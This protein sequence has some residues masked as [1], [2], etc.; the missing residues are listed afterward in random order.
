MNNSLIALLGQALP[1]S[2][3][4]IVGAFFYRKSTRAAML[5]GVIGS[6]SLPALSYIAG[7]LGRPDVLVVSAFYGILYGLGAAYVSK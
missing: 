1:F 2:L 4:G 7:I 5:A 6:I 3:L